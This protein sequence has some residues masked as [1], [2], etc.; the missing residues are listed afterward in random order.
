MFRK[1]LLIGLLIA[2]PVMAKDIPVPIECYQ[3]ATNALDVSRFDAA[4]L[5]AFTA[6]KE[7]DYG[8][9]TDGRIPR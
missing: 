9:E 1:T 7:T 5:I 3:T 6:A 8:I 2:P 4:P